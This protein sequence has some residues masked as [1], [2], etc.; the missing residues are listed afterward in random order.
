MDRKTLIDIGVT[1]SEIRKKI[2]YTQKEL[3]IYMKIPE[4]Q[5]SNFEYGKI[6]NAI[7]YHKYLKLKE[8]YEV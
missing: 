2:G 7:I 4:T 5:I 3:A 1:C 8:E 6:N